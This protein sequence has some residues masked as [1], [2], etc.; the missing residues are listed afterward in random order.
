MRVLDA[1]SGVGEPAREMARFAG[2]RVTGISIN[3]SH[4][5]LAT[6][7]TKIDGLS[8]LVDFVEGDFMVSWT[9]TIDT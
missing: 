9:G 1:G 2:V 4:V 3:E 7:M 5:K 6:H 8:H